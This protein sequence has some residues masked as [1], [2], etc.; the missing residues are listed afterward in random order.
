MARL[1]A[2]G[3][4]DTNIFTGGVGENA[5]K[6]EVVVTTTLKSLRIA[7]DDDLNAQISR[8]CF[9]HQRCW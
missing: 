5:S 2:L 1:A 3:H 7:I 4:V 8:S 6:L 9:C